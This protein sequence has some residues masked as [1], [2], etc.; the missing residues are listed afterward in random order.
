MITD[1]DLPQPKPA[2]VARPPL[3][4]WGVAELEGYMGELR[5]EIARAEAEIGRKNAHRSAA[6]A[7]FRK[8]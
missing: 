4:L 5:A 3:D 7:F 1:D 2:R 8:P 6:D